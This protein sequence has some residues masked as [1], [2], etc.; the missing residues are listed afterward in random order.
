MPTPNMRVCLKYKR[1][2]INRAAIALIGNPTHLNF[3]YDEQGGV[4][5]FSP[6]TADDLDA[7]EIPKYFWTDKDSNCEICRIAFFRA[8]HYRIG[9]EAGSKYLYNGLLTNIDDVPVLVYDL[10]NGT[11][12]R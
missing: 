11:R 5:Y 8:L 6:A 2:N 1:I 12:V 3:R 4:L 7:Y 10:L 9:W